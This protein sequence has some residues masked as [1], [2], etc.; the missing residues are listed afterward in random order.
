M[1]FHNEK[2]SWDSLMLMYM[3]TLGESS[4]F[5]KF[6]EN[7]IQF[8]WLGILTSSSPSQFFELGNEW[9]KDHEGS[10]I[11]IILNEICVLRIV[12]IMKSFL[13]MFCKNFWCSSKSCLN[14]IHNW[15]NWLFFAIMKFLIFLGVLFF[16][17][18]M[19][20][21]RTL[22]QISLIFTFKIQVL[23]CMRTQIALFCF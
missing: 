23:E 9:M 19:P 16:V 17:E 11:K 2:W 4:I 10:W 21:E 14:A 6:L 5:E 20:P 22:I 18:M 15:T 12:L 7:I 1:S 8:G 13:Q 3:I